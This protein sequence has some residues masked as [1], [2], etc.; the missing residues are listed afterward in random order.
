MD[1]LQTFCIYAVITVLMTPL[2]LLYGL[3]F[4]LLARVFNHFAQLW[5][6][7]GTRFIISCAIAALGVAPAYDIYRAPLPIY[8][9]LW[10]QQA[11]SAG[12]M[13]ASFLVTWLLLVLQTRQL[14]HFFGHRD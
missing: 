10:N 14:M 2:L 3:P 6:K 12:F 13:L 1:T 9:W 7:D 11:P 5:L 8:R 4:I